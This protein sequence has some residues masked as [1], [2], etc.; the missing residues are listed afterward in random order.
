MTKWGVIVVSVI[1]IA[2]PLEGVRAEGASACH[3]YRIAEF[4]MSFDA[5]GRVSIPM[6]IG[7][8]TVNL[9]IDTGG[10]ISTLTQATVTDLGLKPQNSRGI[11]ERY[12]GGETLTHYVLVH[13]ALLGAIKGPELGFYVMS[14]GRAA[15]D[16]GGTLSPDILGQFDVDF[17][18][19][20]ARL[21]LF[22]QDHCEGKV[23]YWT[24]Q[25][26]EQIEIHFDNEHH[27]R[28]PLQLDGKEIMADID[29]GA[30]D[31]VGSLDDVED[32]FDLRSND[33]NL[34]LLPGL[35]DGEHIYRYPFKVLS[36]GGVAVYNPHLE[37]WPDADSRT[38]HK[39]LI[40]MNVLRHLH[41]YVAYKEQKLYVTPATEH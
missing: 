16:E 18:F 38:H 4:D 15:L 36:F 7:G 9:L 25:P 17:D 27:L 12:Y 37:L 3:L 14:N 8:R 22:S 24:A 28:V 1:L 11:N 13:D 29:T 6:T 19:A 31:S 2:Y 35:S 21:N 5:S 26:A 41:M 39:F 33:P 30:A 10:Y 40:G 20:N 32:E 34:K 23:V